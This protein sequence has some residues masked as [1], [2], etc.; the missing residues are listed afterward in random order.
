MTQAG[1]RR[2]ATF[3][4]VLD[5]CI[6]DGMLAVDRR[7]VLLSR[8]D[9]QLAGLVRQ[10]LVE[11]REAGGGP[12]SASA[13]QTGPGRA[14]AISPVELL[15][16]FGERGPDDR[17]LREDAV[18]EMWA[19]L[20]GMPYLKLD[21]LELDP[22]F[23]SRVVSRPFA[24]KHGFLAIE[25][26]DGVL[27]IATFDPFDTWALESVERVTGKRLRLVISSKTDVERLITEFYGFRQ[28]VQ[29]AEKQIAV[30]IDLGNLEQFVRMKS[31]QEIEAS[32]EHVVH[33]VDYMLRYAFG[34]GASDIHIEPKRVD[35]A[36]RFRI[37]GSLHAVSRLPRLVHNAVVNR[38]KTLARLDI[39]EKRRPQDGRIRT[40]FQGRGVEMRVS[41][42]PV[43]FGEKVVMRIFDPAL[44]HDDL[45]ALGFFPRDRAIFE[46][47]ITLPHGI[48]LVTGP[49]GSGKTTTLYTALRKL[50][51]EDVNVTTIEDPIEMVFE[52]I[53]QT[54]IM[55]ALGL[56]FAECLRTILR[57]DP[58]IVM[59]GEIRDLDTAKHAIQAALTGHLVFSTLH[60]ND[61]V[62]AVTRLIDLGVQDFL[63]ASTLAGVMAQRL[64]KRV[65]PGCVAE[66]VLTPEEA[67]GLALDTSAGEILVR[68]GAGCAD[69][70]KTGYRGRAALVELFKVTPT[71]RRMIHQRAD[72]ASI[73]EQAQKEGMLT[74]R[75]AA[76]H[77]MLLGETT[78]EQVVEVT[79]AF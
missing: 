45:G 41:T 54:A 29:S 62:S 72:E 37:D 31:D 70:R 77:K 11:Q 48:I 44:V 25:E 56:G 18:T 60:T 50:A 2:R 53:N 42:L 75:E 71:V 51:T 13:P 20:I 67:K 43:A 27:T 74:L 52:G 8:K 61:A 79:T 33:A 23:A 19:G 59:V 15:L 17:P 26:R 6:L 3:E 1:A 78:Y 65:C 9:A 57:Q 73:K 36:V 32:D 39:S 34:Q 64:V 46:E 21:P 12:A 4:E 68:Y 55:P 7:A 22:A 63:L 30:G 35:S 14:P 76:T 24:R 47:L 5:A 66:R 38:I 10:R 58:D 28:S 40:E 69:C 49:T 16:S